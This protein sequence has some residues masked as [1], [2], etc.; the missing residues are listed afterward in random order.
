FFTSV[1]GPEKK[2]ENVRAVLSWCKQPISIPEW[3]VEG[4]SYGFSRDQSFNQHRPFHLGW[5]NEYLIHWQELPEEQRNM[6]LNDPWRFAQDVR[7]V[8]FEHGAYQPMQEAW[9]YM[10]FPDYFEDISSRSN[11]RQI[12]D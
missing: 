3:A 5:L 12:R 2:L 6:L 9:L 1:T 11:K 7:D 10:I 4:V 8:K